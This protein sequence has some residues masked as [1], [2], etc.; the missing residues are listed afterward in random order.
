MHAF[1]RA[2]LLDLHRLPGW[3][4]FEGPKRATEPISARRRGGVIAQ[5]EEGTG[6]VEEITDGQVD[7][8]HLNCRRGRSL[9]GR[10]GRT[11]H[12]SRRRN[13]AFFTT[14]ARAWNVKSVQ[15]ACS[16][17]VLG[18]LQGSECRHLPQVRAFSCW[19]VHLFRRQLCSNMETI[20]ESGS[21]CQASGS[22]TLSLTCAAD[23]LPTTVSLRLG[24]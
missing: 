24:L 14:R 17:A 2:T 22:V 11:T 8:C 6:R 20:R 4:R 7:V 10:S 19:R 23:S 13:T 16:G 21:Y 1:I 15:S 9:A 3:T 5:E 12:P 18:A